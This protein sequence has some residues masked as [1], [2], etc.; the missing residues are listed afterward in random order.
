MKEIKTTEKYV[1]PEFARGTLIEHL[2][3]CSRKTPIVKRKA[4]YNFWYNLTK[5]FK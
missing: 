3:K 2:E 4:S 1:L 5:F